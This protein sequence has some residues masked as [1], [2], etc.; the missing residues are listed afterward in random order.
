MK[1]NWNAICKIFKASRYSYSATDNSSHR[2]SEE[3]CT[4]EHNVPLWRAKT[5]LGGKDYSF[6]VHSVS[7]IP[8]IYLPSPH[9]D[10]DVTFPD[11]CV[12][13]YACDL[14]LSGAYLISLAPT[15]ETS[16]NHSIQLLF[17]S[18]PWS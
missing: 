16:T 8:A 3:L 5:E 17:F 11:S 6:G 1:E 10:K 14:Q 9:N 4:K 2:S 18:D 13:K 7:V 12:P 15:D